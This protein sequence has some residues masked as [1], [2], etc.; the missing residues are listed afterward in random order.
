MS[1]II[2]VIM[3][4]NIASQRVKGVHD[5]VGCMFTL[6]NGTHTARFTVA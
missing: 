2:N 3:Q 1:E 4:L 6:S 5:A